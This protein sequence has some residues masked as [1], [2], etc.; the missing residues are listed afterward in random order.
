MSL[1]VKFY[2]VEHGSCTHIIT[3]NEQHFLVDIG[4]KADKSIC[5]YLKER[6]F[7]DGGQLDWLVITHPHMDHIKDLENLYACDLEPRSFWCDSRAFPLKNLPDDTINQMAVKNIANEMNATYQTEIEY[8]KASTNPQYNGGIDIE[9]FL[10]II[11][12]SE[13]EDLNVFSCVM[14][15]NY[16]GRKVVLTGDNPASKLEEMMERADFRN[17]IQDATVLLAPHHGRN[18][19]FC[20]SFV[21]HVK[22]AVTVISDKSIKHATQAYTTD[23]YAEFC[24][25]ARWNETIR[26]VFTTRNDGTIT[27]QFTEDSSVNVSACKDE[28]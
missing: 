23:K 2:D 28:Y 27:F 5:E 8:D 17:S 15:L 18:S 26:Y 13:R 24:R 14:V 25:G 4:T 20:E 21:A 3:P 1:T 12:E 22:P 16:A 6:Y 11:M 19:D 7:S 10:P 9:I